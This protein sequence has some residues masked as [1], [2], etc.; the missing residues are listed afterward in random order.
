MTR[1]R[2]NTEEKAK[3]TTL[4]AD[5]QRPG[6]IAKVVQR[7]PHTVRKFLQEPEAQRQVEDEKQKLAE[8]YRTEARRILDSIS[9]KDIERASLQQKSISSGVLLDKSLLLAGEATSINVTVLLDAV[10][11]VKEHRRAQEAQQSPQEASSAPQG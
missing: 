7:S 6:R 10:R 5:G 4:A 8:R 2:L 3:I 11:A 9:D 1:E